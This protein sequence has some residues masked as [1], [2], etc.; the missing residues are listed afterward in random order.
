MM[1]G[2]PFRILVV[3]DDEDDR[4]I[5][6]EAFQEIGYQPEVKKFISGEDMFR[7]LEQIDVSL[8]PSLIVLDNTLPK[9]DATAIVSILKNNTASDKIPVVILTTSISPEKSKR[10]LEMG[11]YAIIEKGSEMKEII[12]IARELKDIAET[13]RVEK[14]QT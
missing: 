5:L 12:R 2:L 8:F 7:Y 14:K 13:N 3:E 4:I 10:L 1:E 9:L 6:D 11:V